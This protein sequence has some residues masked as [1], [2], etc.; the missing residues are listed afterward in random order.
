MAELLVRA[1][2]LVATGHPQRPRR[3]AP[4]AAQRPADVE[5]DRLAGAD[6]PLR[7]LVVGR[8][9][10]GPRSDDRE[11]GELVTLGPEPVADFVRDVRLGPSDEAPGGDLVDDSVGRLG[12]EAQQLDLVGVLDHPQAAQDARRRGPLGVRQVGLEP[13][14]VVGSEPVRHGDPGGRP[15]SPAAAR[16]SSA[17]MA[18]GSS[19]SI[20]VVIGISVRRPARAAGSSRRGAIR[21]GCRSPA[22]TS[23][24]SRSSGIA[25]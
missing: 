13:E 16:T 11:L 1:V 3:V 15:A 2:G 24:V 20:Q 25:R 17:A 18:C 23:I 19:V 6:H 5:D 10:V 4:V 14:Q 12:R 22:T 21:T 9:G 7:R 8:R